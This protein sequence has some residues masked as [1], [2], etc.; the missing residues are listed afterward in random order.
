MQSAAQAIGLGAGPAVGG[1]VLDTLGWHGVA[2]VEFKVNRA[3]LKLFE[4]D[5]LDELVK[6]LDQV[7]RPSVVADRGIGHHS[8]KLHNALANQAHLWPTYGNAMA[9]ARRRSCA[10]RTRG[11]CC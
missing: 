8:P 9:A 6:E 5:T 4:A 3:T 11:S 2:M 1:L 10:P 7:F